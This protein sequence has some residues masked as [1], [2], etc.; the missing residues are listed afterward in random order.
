M[1][2]MKWNMIK[3]LLK[4]GTIESKLNFDRDFGGSNDYR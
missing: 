4:N 3:I 2:S 1:I